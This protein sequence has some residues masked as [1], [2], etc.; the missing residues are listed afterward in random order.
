[1]NKGSKN[2]NVR[3]DSPKNISVHVNKNS[4]PYLSGNIRNSDV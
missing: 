4:K 1:M 3:V 2:Q